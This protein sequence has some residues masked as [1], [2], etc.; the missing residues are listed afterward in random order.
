VQPLSFSLLDLSR[1][2]LRAPGTISQKDSSVPQVAAL[3]GSR[4]AELSAAVSSGIT[5]LQ[6]SVAS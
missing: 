5:S 4:T 2:S 6:R 3:S 1:A